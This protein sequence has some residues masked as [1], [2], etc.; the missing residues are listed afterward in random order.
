MVSFGNGYAT[1]NSTKLDGGN[2]GIF[3]PPFI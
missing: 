1:R 3:I 2:E